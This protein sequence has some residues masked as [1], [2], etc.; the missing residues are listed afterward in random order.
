MQFSVHAAKTQLSKLIEAA[1][2]GE[3]VVI[4]KGTR[5]V[6]RLVPIRQSGFALGTH[7][8]HFG[9]PPDFL[10]PMS[11]AEADEWEGR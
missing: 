3:E 6:V 9:T 2:S 5:P 4:A 8:G 7:R 10:E 11:E 1:L